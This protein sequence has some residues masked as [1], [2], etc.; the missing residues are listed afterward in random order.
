MSAQNQCPDPQDLV[1]YL[2][3][4]TP[5]D[6]RDPIEGHLSVCAGCRPGTARIFRLRGEQARERFPVSGKPSRSF[7]RWGWGIAASILLAA[8]LGSLWVGGQKPVVSSSA[9]LIQGMED[10]LARP[11]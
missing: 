8:G 10:R 6:Q 1:G 11:G 7:R 4:G 5:Q 2:S 9:H 3:G